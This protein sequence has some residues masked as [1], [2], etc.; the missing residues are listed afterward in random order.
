MASPCLWGSSAL[1][2]LHFGLH[3]PHS[4]L[5]NLHS[6]LYTLHFTLY[7]PHSTL[8]TPHS[9]LYTLYTPHST[10]YTSHSLLYTPHSTLYT[11]HSTLQTGNRGNMYKTVQISYCRKALCV[12]AYPCVATSSLSIRDSTTFQHPVA[13][14]PKAE[15][16]RGTGCRAS[17]AEGE[18][19][20]LSAHT[21]SKS[22]QLELWGRGCLG[23]KQ[24]KETLQTSHLHSMVP[25][26]LLLLRSPNCKI[27]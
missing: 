5:E 10:L 2:T 20:S 24:G 18:T 19:L 13:P 6:S 17:A 3:T 22:F 4:S 7:T 14:R 21:A 1:H 11:F 8:Y 15:R 27:I 12:T 25:V 23:W 9:T 26:V 16:R